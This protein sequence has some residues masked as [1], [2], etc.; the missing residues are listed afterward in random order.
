MKTKQR[1]EWGLGGAAAMLGLAAV[2]YAGFAAAAWTRY[3]R[4]AAPSADE[5]DPLLD[6]FMPAYDI[7]ERHRVVVRAPL[8][9]TFSALMDMNLDDS[10]LVRAIFKGRELLMG[11]GP[12]A[13][14]TAR[15]L[16]A[17]TRELGWVVLAEVPGREIVMGAVTRPWEAHVVFRGIPAEQF[18]AYNEPGYVKIAWTLRVDGMGPSVSVARTETRAV[19]T[20]AAARRKF[21]WYWTRFSAGIVVI[22]EL[23]LC[24]VKKEAERRALA[25]S[26]DE[27]QASLPGSVATTGAAATAEGA[28]RP[29]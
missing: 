12:D 26:L 18:A 25:L 3:G 20:D 28:N 4:A 23:S 22:R 7:A 1:V 29:K 9:V 2:S 19:A 5:A 6:G 21:R 16:V 13:K 24:L 8:N 27:T 10:V 14:T 11:A 17:I 15:T